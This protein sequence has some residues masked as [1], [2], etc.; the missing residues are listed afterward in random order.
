M[1]CIFQG[2]NQRVVHGGWGDLLKPTKQHLRNQSFG[3]C[4]NANDRLDSTISACIST[5]KCR[6][7]QKKTCQ[8]SESRLV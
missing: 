5:Q 4:D 7:L 1:I 3:L 2:S 8:P 6:S